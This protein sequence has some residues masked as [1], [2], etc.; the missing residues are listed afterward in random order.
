MVEQNKTLK[1]YVID[2]L[3]NYFAKLENTPIDNLYEIVLNEVEQGLLEGIMR[4][5]K[6]NQSK[7][8]VLLGLSRGT[9]RKKLKRYN[10]IL[11]N[12]YKKK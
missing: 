10:L 2:V 9:T 12:Q 8:A 11:K 4:H 7:A 1:N 5:T 3:D 6:R